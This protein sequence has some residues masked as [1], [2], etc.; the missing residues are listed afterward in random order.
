MKP[1]VRHVVSA[2]LTEGTD[3]FV[4]LDTLIWHA[5]ATAG[6]RLDCPGLVHDVALALVE[7]GLAKIGELGDR[8]IPWPGTPEQVASRL[9]AQCAHFDWQPQGAGCWI[10]NT[11]AGDAWVQRPTKE[12]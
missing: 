12:A 3:D 1:Q 6:D 7:G 8:I 11:P 4:P 9:V 2:V 5:R 10:E